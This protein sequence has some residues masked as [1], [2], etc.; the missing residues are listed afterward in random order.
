[1]KIRFGR[2]RESFCFAGPIY[3]D[4]SSCTSLR[5]PRNIG[6]IAARRN[7]ETGHTTVP[8]HQYALEN[9]E[10][11]PGHLHLA[12]IETDG[13]QTAVASVHKVAR[14][15]VVGMSAALHQ[16]SSLPGAQRDSGDLRIV[17]GLGSHSGHGK[18]KGFAS[19]ESVREFQHALLFG[20]VNLDDFLRLPA[21]R[22]YA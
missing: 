15:R 6:E 3:P 22:R 7:I 13:E 2:Q 8:A 18:Q 12:W 19:G 4:Q 5:F 10:G 20:G 14:R 16:D 11:L 17:E 21:P 9:A 1:M